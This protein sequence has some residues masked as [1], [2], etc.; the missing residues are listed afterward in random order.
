LSLKWPQDRLSSFLANYLPKFLGPGSDR[1]VCDD[2]AL[3]A[4]R[5]SIIRKLR[6]AKVQ[7]QSVST[8]LIGKAVATIEWISS[9]AGHQ[10]RFGHSPSTRR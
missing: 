1:M 3:A 5:S 4:S 10:T 6:E 8:E 7:P 2:D 9:R